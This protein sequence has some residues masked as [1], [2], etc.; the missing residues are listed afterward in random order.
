MSKTTKIVL[1][2][3]PS[4]GKTQALNILKIKL[5]AYGIKVFTVTEAAA[6]LLNS[7]FSGDKPGYEFQKAIAM[8]QIEAEEKAEEFSKGYKSLIICDR[9]LMDSKVYLNN[10]EF[11]RLKKDLNMTDIELRDRYDAVFHMDS[12]SKYDSVIYETDD[13]RDETREEAQSINERSLRAWCGNPHYRFIPVCD[14]FEEKFDILL[15][16]VKAFLGIPKPLEIERKFLIKFPDIDYLLTLNCAKSEIEQSYLLGE[17]GK[18]RLRKRGENG[19]YFYIKTIKKK[20]SDTVREEDETRLTR[21]EYRNLL[22]KNV[23]TG[24]IKKDRYCLMYNGTYYEID[25][26]P[27]WKKQAYLEVELL[28][29]N[30]EIK[31]PAFIKVIREVTYD[32]RYKNSSLCRSVPDED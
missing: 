21:D 9:G 25:V 17:E 15:R 22:K 14:S 2:G 4:G 6:G 27:F 3:G 8:W 16:E 5:E 12:T 26:F 20:L 19:S 24:T 18:F 23:V 1:T 11:K 29:E 13:I 30:D 32:P 7:G 31:L 28:N 10:K